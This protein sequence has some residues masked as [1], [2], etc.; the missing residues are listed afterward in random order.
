MKKNSKRYQ[1]LIESKIK[2]KKIDIKE[3]I[4]FVKKIQIQNLMNL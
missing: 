4:E 3:I 2:D 1:K